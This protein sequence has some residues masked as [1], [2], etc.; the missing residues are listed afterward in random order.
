VTPERWQHVKGVVADAMERPLAERAQF[1]AAVCGD[2]TTL[3]LEA[4][5]I[6]SQS[7]DTLERCV[8]KMTASASQYDAFLGV[9]L[10]AYEVVRE[11]GRGGMGA[12]Y[13]ARRADETFKKDVAVK[14]LKRGTDTDEVLRR[15]HAERQIVARLEHPNIARLIDAGTTADGLPY[16]VMEYADGKP[17]TEFCRE[18]NSDTR[19]RIKLMLAVCDAVHFAHQN[20]VVHRDLKPGNILVTAEGA[21]KLLDFGIAKLL[22]DSPEAAVTIETRQ[23]LTPGYASPEQVR[24]EPITTATDVYSLGALLFHL[25]TGQPA[26][27]FST[28]TPPPTELARVIAEAVPPRA[29]KVAQTSELRRELAGDLDTILATALQKEPER[30]YSGVLAFA[31][32]LQRYLN[33]RPIKARPAELGYR[34][35]KFVARNR[36]AVASA[37]VVLV[38]AFAGLAAYVRQVRRVAFHAEHEAAHFRDLRTLANLFIFKYQN[39]IAA[40]PGSTELRKELVKDALA[41]LNNLATR[42][43]SGDPELLREVASGYKRIADV[44]GGVLIDEKTGETVSGANLGDMAGALENYGKSLKIRAQLASLY[45]EDSAL[46]YEL[47][48]IHASLG[49]FNDSVARPVDAAGYF[50][51][52]IQLLKPLAEKLP[53]DKA[54]RA[55]LRTTYYRLATTLA[56]EASNLGDVPGAFEALG[57]GIPIGEALVADDPTNLAHRQGLAPLYSARGRLLMAESRAA[58]ALVEYRKALAM[59]TTLV[60]ERP[61]NPYFRAEL[62][63]TQ[64]NVAAA[65]SASGAQAD[66]LEHYRTAVALF[67]QLMIED[68]NDARLRRS[69]AY[70]IRDLGEAMAAAGERIAA[71]QNMERA[72]AIF[73][74]LT[75]RDP[76]LGVAMTQQAVTHLKLSRFFAAEDDL[77]RARASAERAVAVADALVARESA[78]VVTQKTAADAS[79]QLG[80]VH[81]TA[82]ERADRASDQKR[83]RAAAHDA[84]RKSEATWKR[85]EERGK[86]TTRDRASVAEVREMLAGADVSSVPP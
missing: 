5:A 17:I 14:V 81:L 80:K 43:G 64:R 6:I 10:G 8:E 37:T 41:Y 22:S 31:D 21:P 25:L 7:A 66:A 57:H 30:R 11:I 49:F 78:D 72:L 63:I 39:G 13:L 3:R 74:E 12:V 62:A 71:Q 15:F 27:Q 18:R 82:A 54:V 42:T 77:P 86:L 84:F 70:G 76:K 9:R 60:E 45:P 36:I 46:Q 33:G 23:R 4:A 75:A 38:A 58:D 59:I 79:T 56:V 32:D 69:A 35:S 53:N 44:Q 47:G 1:L 24:N 67:E 83:L 52:A 29:S 55:A 65:L 73:E 16:F 85:L 20:L 40:L 51:T 28:A 19:Q 61:G 50:R 34:A 26:H 48:Q 68:P 2:D